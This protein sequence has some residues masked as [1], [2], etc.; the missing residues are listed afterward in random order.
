MMLGQPALWDGGR[1]V[2]WE[3]GPITAFIGGP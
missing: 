2:L 1:Q 3:A